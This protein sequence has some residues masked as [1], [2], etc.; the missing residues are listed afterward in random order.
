MSIVQL[1]THSGTTHFYTATDTY[2]SSSYY[3]QMTTSVPGS[4]GVLYVQG[5]GVD[6]TYTFCNI[7]A[8]N[9]TE[10]NITIGLDPGGELHDCFEAGCLNRE[11][12]PHFCMLVLCNNIGK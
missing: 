11:Q 9:E 12:L 4:N 6:E 5:N 3:E 7:Q 8:G 10:S 2:P 1:A